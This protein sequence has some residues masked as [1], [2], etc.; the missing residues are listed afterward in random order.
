M[1]TEVG[2][3]ET[4]LHL[5]LRV[6]SILEA[7][8]GSVHDPTGLGTIHS[9]AYF[10]DALSHAWGFSPIE[11]VVLKRSGLPRSPRLQV[12]IDR[13]VGGGVVIP[14]RVSHIEQDSGQWVLQGAFTLNED[15]STRILNTMA[16][17]EH[18]LRQLT[19]TKEVAW[20]VA[21]LGADGTSA[22]QVEASYADP[23]VDTNELIDLEPDEGQLSRTAE[24]SRSLQVLARDRLGRPLSDAELTNLYVRHLYGLLATADD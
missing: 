24:V 3:E 1:A 14:H 2:A 18:W 20:S 5:Q 17:D 12:A 7:Y 13:L 8:R 9:V 23:L 4:T 16:H 11:D 10:V 15:F 22:V 21:G 19:F 6:V